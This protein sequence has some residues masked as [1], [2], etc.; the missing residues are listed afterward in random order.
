MNGGLFSNGVLVVVNCSLGRFFSVGEV[1][2]IE[3]L[4]FYVSSIGIF[5]YVEFRNVVVNDMGFEML[6]FLLY[7]L[8]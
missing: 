8:F 6:V 4:V 7:V 3:V 1:M 2:N 5:E